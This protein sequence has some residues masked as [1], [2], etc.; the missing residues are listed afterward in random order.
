[1]RH[2][3]RLLLLGHARSG[4]SNLYQILQAHPDLN[5]LEEPFN[6]RYV[7]WKPG[8]EDFRSRVRDVASLDVVLADIFIRFNGLKLLEYQLP[9]DL[10]EP[11]VKRA[12]L[13]VVFIR[14]RN[15]LQA[16]VSGLIAEQTGLWKIWDMTRP[17]AS[18]YSGL[19]PL[20]LDVIWERI[21]WLS[22]HLA[23]CEEMLDG[24]ADGRS[25]GVLYEDLYF[26]PPSEQAG[27]LDS[28]WEFLGLER[29]D[30]GALDYYLRPE[31]TKLN[32]AAT[33]ASVPN[34]QEVNKKCGSDAFGWLFE[35]R[36]SGSR[37][38]P[39]EAGRS[40]LRIPHGED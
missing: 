11:L 20:D 6:E 29:L 14:R 21:R 5:I 8:N 36:P 25:W 7:T 1:M 24:R 23:A 32:S 39:V 12:D 17:L 38:P 4:S 34:I 9:D 31:R 28:L 15:L 33:Y 40:A 30:P 27:R 26:S 35:Q 22:E 37:G 19:E 2:G 16:V 10:L 13:S 3:D 18:Y